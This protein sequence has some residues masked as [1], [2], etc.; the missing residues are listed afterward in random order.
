[1]KQFFLL[2]PLFV[3]LSVSQ[4]FA[5]HQFP[6]VP[7]NHPFHEVIAY[8]KERGII[9]AYPDGKFRPNN[10]IKRVEVLRILFDSASIPVPEVLPNDTVGFLDVTPR[11]WYV[12]Y[13]K[14]A[15]ERGI[16]SGYHNGTFRPTN[17]VKL[18]EAL[19]ILFLARDIT[20]P[21]L[22]FKT[23]DWFAKYIT[24]A[25]EKG[26]LDQNVSLQPGLNLS[27]AAFATLA[28]RLRFILTGNLE[29]F[30]ELKWAEYEAKK[31]HQELKTQGA[32]LE[33]GP[34]LHPRIIPNWAADIVHVPRQP[35]D[36][37][38]LNGCFPNGKQTAEH[39]IEL[40]PEGNVVDP[41]P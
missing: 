15:K 2:V 24:F 38:P 13:I 1:M 12:R 3:F 31:L 4:V 32:Y 8:L 19:K 30:S 28:F 36:E 5:S 18:G 41:S 34:C 14:V 20:V 11:Q 17:T 39:V 10:P 25:L 29:R 23:E 40:D 26:M 35:I 22:P 16:I 21:E 9:D 33:N 6:D 7:G 37:D 27:R